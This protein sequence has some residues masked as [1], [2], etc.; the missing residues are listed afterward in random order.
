MFYIWFSGDDNKDALANS[1][2]FKIDWKWLLKNERAKA[3]YDKIKENILNEAAIEILTKRLVET[4]KFT[5]KPENFDFIGDPWKW[6]A[7]HHQS[8]QLAAY[9]PYYLGEFDDIMIAL[10]ACSL[11]GIAKGWIEPLKDGSHRIHID[12]A[13]IGLYDA[14][15]FDGNQVLGLWS[16][17]QKKF[18]GWDWD[19]PNMLWNYNFNSFRNNRKKG[20]DFLVITDPKYVEIPKGFFYDTSL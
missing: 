18:L 7:M 1:T 19:N 11:Y 6:K 10:G 8:R 9:N 16:C 20:N 14:F 12:E 2:P 17:E 3:A 15:N 5:D 13:A 4:N